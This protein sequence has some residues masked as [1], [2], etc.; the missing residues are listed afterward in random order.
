[1]ATKEKAEEAKP[2]KAAPTNR[3]IETATLRSG[4]HV[5]V[6]YYQTIEDVDKDAGK[7][8][9][10]LHL[11]NT[12]MQQK[13]ALPEANEFI[14]DLIV[15]LG[16]PVDA[17]KNKVVEK[18]DDKGVKQKVTINTETEGERIAR[19]ILLVNEGKWSHT[20]VTKGAAKEFLQAK[21]V[22]HGPFWLD[23]S[24]PIR[25]SKPK[26][27][28]K[29]ALDAANSVFDDTPEFSGAAREKFKKHWEAKINEGLKQHGSTHVF[30]L[31]GVHADDKLAFAWA[32][33]HRD[34]AKR[35]NE[36]KSEFSAPLK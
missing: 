12:Y 16:F 26:T 10:A 17:T 19:F 21:L 9:A 8:G 30:K 5:Q 33:H 32:V 6:G 15:E 22:T 35:A 11:V 1:M 4:L 34:E 27:P 29:Y 24:T 3:K 25:T 18:E 13:S 14:S 20:S 23:A 2:V 36:A 7:T 28:P 31:S